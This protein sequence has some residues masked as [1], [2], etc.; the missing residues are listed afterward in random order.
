ML[1]V[2]NVTERSSF[3]MFIDYLINR[4]VRIDMVQDSSTFLYMCS[5]SEGVIS[6]A[7]ILFN[8]TQLNFAFSCCGKQINEI[9]AII[10]DGEDKRKIQRIANG[11]NWVI[12]P[13]DYTEKTYRFVTS[14]SSK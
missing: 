7:S 14:I 6:D 1:N 2:C 12:L 8:A 3:Y 9:T 10:F 11:L 5:N 4:R 13:L